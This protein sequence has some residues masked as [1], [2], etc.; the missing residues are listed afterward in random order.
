MVLR[1]IPLYIVTGFVHP[2]AKTQYGVIDAPA[3]RRIDLVA[4]YR[5]APQQRHKGK[6]GAIVTV[7]HR[8][9]DPIQ[10]LLGLLIVQAAGQARQRF[11]A[12]VFTF[13]SDHLQR[14]RD[15]RFLRCRDCRLAV[16]V[17][18]FDA[19]RAAYLE[20][21]TLQ[22][23]VEIAEVRRNSFA[24][25]NGDQRLAGGES[26]IE[27]DRFIQRDKIPQH[28]DVQAVVRRRGLRKYEP[29]GAAVIYRMLEGNAVQ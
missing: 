4:P 2:V 6:V 25:S 11:D 10:H 28:V 9:Q 21:F 12:A 24:F 7:E 17:A 20:P 5:P 1:E 13:M 22:R 16:G 27:R 8:R 19:Q 18:D 23:D 26:A 14:F 3:N 29:N 15:P